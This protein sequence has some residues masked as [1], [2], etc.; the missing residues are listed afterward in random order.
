MFPPE[1]LAASGQAVWE[2]DEA[3]A[4]TVPIQELSAAA[5]QGAFPGPSGSVSE[6]GLPL[7]LNDRLVEVIERIERREAGIPDGPI[8]AL[9]RPDLWPELLARLGDLPARMKAACQEFRGHLHAMRGY[10]VAGRAACLREGYV[11]LNDAKTAAEF[12]DIALDLAALGDDTRKPFME[13]ASARFLQER[14]RE[15]FP[16]LLLEL[17]ALSVGIVADLRSE[18][19]AREAEASRTSRE[20]TGADLT[21][22][23]LTAKVDRLE[24]TIAR[25]LTQARGELECGPREVPG[26]YFEELFT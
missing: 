26:L 1:S 4:A 11:R 15:L 6:A 3:E 17:E 13:Q 8:G 10:T 22:R 25:L 18:A 12:R 20:L 24:A 14:F 16:A 23:P 21:A 2:G 7:S 19:T 9:G 5:P